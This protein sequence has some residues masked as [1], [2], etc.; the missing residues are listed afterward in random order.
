MWYLMLYHCSSVNFMVYAF[1]FKK[2]YADQFCHLILNMFKVNLNYFKKQY[3]IIVLRFFSFTEKKKGGCQKHHLWYNEKA[4]RMRL[5]N[6]GK[7]LL[8][9]LQK[10]QTRERSRSHQRTEII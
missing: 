1:F 6:D 10:S 3:G 2:K 7:K 4:K 9:M 8:N 5:Y